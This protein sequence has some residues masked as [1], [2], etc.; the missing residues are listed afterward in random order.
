VGGGVLD[1]GDSVCAFG[2]DRF[3]LYD[4]GREGTAEAG[5]YI[6]DGKLDRFS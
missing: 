3:V 4:Q 6:L 2:R 5:L 1:G